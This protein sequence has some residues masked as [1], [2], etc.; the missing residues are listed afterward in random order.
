MI[1]VSAR[2]IVLA[3]LLAASPQ[4][5]SANDVDVKGAGGSWRPADGE[6]PSV[7]MVRERVRVDVYRTHYHVTAD[8]E[9][10]NHGPA[11]TVHMGFPERGD[12]AGERVAFRNFVTLVDGRGARVRR[13]VSTPGVDEARDPDSYLA[14]WIKQVPFG[15]RQRRRVRVSYDAEPGSTALLGPFASYEFSGQNWNGR[16]EESAVT[17]ARHAFRARPLRA[18]FAGKPFDL[19]RSGALYTYRWRDWEAQGH[20]SL[21]YDANAR[22]WRTVE[23]L[24]QSHE[25]TPS[26]QVPTAP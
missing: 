19:R 17:V 11:T 9:F 10:L 12:G 4:A 15:A 2:T 8:F 1:G 7:Q 16:V 21:Y 13:V 23:R 25:G 14:L 18:M 6:N 5:S 20:L 22:E 3:G 26:S 24:I